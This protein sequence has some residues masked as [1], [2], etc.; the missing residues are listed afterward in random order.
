MRP[1]NIVECRVI[2]LSDLR[3]LKLFMYHIFRGR[4]CTMLE[5]IKTIIYT[6]RKCTCT[7]IFMCAPRK[8]DELEYVDNDRCHTNVR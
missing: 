8:L 5:D 1:C 4:L 7:C 2:N 6:L 3:S